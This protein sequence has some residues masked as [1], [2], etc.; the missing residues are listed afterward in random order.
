MNTAER[1]LRYLVSPAGIPNYGDELIAMTWLR[2]LREVA[3]DDDVVVDCHRPGA[4]ARRMAQLHPRVRF[5]NTLWE[6]CTRG[7]SRQA[8]RT[9]E[10]VAAAVRDP[11]GTGELAAGI[12]ELRRAGRVH[13]VGGGFINAIWPPF[14]GLLAGI[15][16][17]CAHSGGLAAMT[18]QGLWPPAQHAEAL[19]RSLVERF[20][21]VDLRDARSAEFA[22]TGAAGHSCDDVFL[23]FGPH[24]LDGGDDVPE[25]M[26]SVQSFLTGAEPDELVGS[27]ADTLRSW[28]AERVGLLE[29]APDQDRKVL[30]LLE[31]TFPSAR[32]YSLEE[33]LTRGLPVRPDQCWISTRFHPHLVAAA[34]GASGI[35]V[36]IRPDYYG[37]KHRSLIEGGSSWRLLE[38]LEMPG[39]PAGG[40]YGDQ[41]LR[42][43]RDAKRAVADRVHARR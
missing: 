36:D 8:S 42:A 38:A 33:V 3:P 32:R 22:G 41:R 35:A 1:P 31:R 16:E 40:G 9:C 20:D 2:Y 21:V 4:A 19:T 43:L 30:E 5:T 39:R 34:G 26:V 18:G 28:G 7:W 25:A 10:A 27:V 29:C 12:E 6:L 11:S 23:G 15:V 17:A 24:L 37:T 14:V 13:L